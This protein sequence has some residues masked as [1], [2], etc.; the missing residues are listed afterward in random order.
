MFGLALKTYM[1][2]RGNSLMKKTRNRAVTYYRCCTNALR[3]LSNH[4]RG[5][6]SV[7]R[8]L[9]NGA[10]HASCSGCRPH[11]CSAVPCD[12]P[13]Y[14]VTDLGGL[15]PGYTL[16]HATTRGSWQIIFWS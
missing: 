1:K 15:D 13:G 16:C 8:A 2:T 5:L 7:L 3:G 9:A 4:N 6:S 10:V 14:R 12:L 11:D